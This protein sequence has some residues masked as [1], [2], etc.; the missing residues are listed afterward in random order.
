MLFVFFSV[1]L[2]SLLVHKRTHS[3]ISSGFILYVTISKTLLVHIR[4]HYK[5]NSLYLF[6]N[7]LAR[8]SNIKVEVPFRQSLLSTF[9][10]DATL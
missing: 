10:L 8:Y 7:I 9:F 1:K 4:A 5:A 3:K 6:K 2:R